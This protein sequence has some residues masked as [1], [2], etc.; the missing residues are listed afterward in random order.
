M[1]CEKQSLIQQSNTIMTI[2]QLKRQ[3][4]YNDRILFIWHWSQKQFSLQI[5]VLYI[6]TTYLSG[7]KVFLSSNSKL[8][9]Q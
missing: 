4:C 8:N 7:R 1:M 2:S 5:A 6:G 9:V 3:Q